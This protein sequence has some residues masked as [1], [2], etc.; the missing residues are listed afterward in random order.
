MPYV[1]GP[2]RVMIEFGGQYNSLTAVN[3]F[4]FVMSTGD[5]ASGTVRVYGLAK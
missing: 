4:R 3:A 2:I 5:I 1:S